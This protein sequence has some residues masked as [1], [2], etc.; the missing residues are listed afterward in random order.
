[1]QF[2]ALIGQ[3]VTPDSLV[4]PDSIKVVRQPIQVSSIANSK[5]QANKIGDLHHSRYAP[6][7][8]AQAPFCHRK[9]VL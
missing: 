8:P 5:F 2:N 9:M 7:P 3:Q 4:R 1:M 6:M